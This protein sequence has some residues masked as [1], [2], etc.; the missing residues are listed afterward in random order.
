MLLSL[1]LTVLA[2]S[3]AQEAPAPRVLVVNSEVVAP[4]APSSLAQRL[5]AIRRQAAPPVDTRFQRLREQQRLAALY[6]VRPE[7]ALGAAGRRVALGQAPQQVRG[8][9][10]LGSEG[11]RAVLSRPQLPQRRPRGRR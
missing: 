7:D 2:V 1:A 4:P 9:A 3:P 5:A 11:R 8:D 10:R 6:P